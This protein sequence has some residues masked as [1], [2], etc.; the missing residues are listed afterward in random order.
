MDALLQGHPMPTKEPKKLRETVRYRA[1]VAGALLVSLAI[2]IGSGVLG[3]LNARAQ[4]EDAA[5][6]IRTHA[7]LVVLNQVETAM[8]DAETGQRG[9]LL[10]G[11]KEFL[12]PWLA[13][14]GEGTVRVIRRPP[15]DALLQSVRKL[16][17]TNSTENALLGRVD[18][19][20][21]EKLAELKQTIA[22]RQAGRI[23]DALTI[24]R[25]GRGKRIMDAIRMA[26]SDM[27]AE[28]RRQLEQSEARRKLA[29]RRAYISAT[30]SC[31]VSVLA[32][33]LLL[34]AIRRSSMDVVREKDRFQMLADH[35]SQH[36]WT[37]DGNGRFEW[38]NWRWHEFTGAAG[39]DLDAQWRAASDH[40]AHRD[41]VER[42]LLHAVESGE[43]WQDIFPLRA[44]DGRWH[45]FMVC[46][47]PIRDAD[48]RVRRWFGTNTNIDERWQLEQELKAGN[49]R[50]DEFIATLAHEL[51]NPLAPIQAG[52]ELMRINPAFPPPLAKTREV[53]RR[54]L[55]HLVRLIDDLLDVSRISTGK[56]ELMRETVPLR[57]IVESA[58][59]VSRLHIETC[60]HTLDVCLPDEPLVVAADPV[61]LAQVLSNLLNNG[62]KYTPAGGSIRLAAQR[63]GNEVAVCVIDNG[64]GIDPAV[65][66]DIFDLFSQ[67]P[68]GSEL[69]Q[70]GIGIGLSIARKLVELHGG[71]LVAKSAG[72]GHGSCFV[73]RLPLAHAEALPPAT[74]ATGVAAPAGARQRILILDD[75]ED[76]AQTLGDL[77]GLMGHT[78][79]LAHTGREA[80]TVAHRFRPEIAFL[81]IGL[82]DIS[83]YE[84]A[85]LIRAA[86][87]LEGIYLVALTG[88]GAAED[89]AKSAEAGFDLHLTKP[90]S[91]DALK[92]ALPDLMAESGQ[93]AE[94]K[95]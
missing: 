92:E 25:E 69:R 56:L 28:E 53:M 30:A 22:L 54:Q 34:A 90:V 50:R 67:A 33:L 95:G 68:H 13:A 12:E 39:R 3:Y 46:A 84:V 6:V 82:P 38:F 93:G 42:G 29:A 88:W 26:L 47:V 11:E 70:G 83:G 43:S 59:E 61:R 85:R 91:L 27:R 87:E 55:K 32:I 86:P 36:A 9:Y 19:L 49:R 4:D 63:D 7:I 45:W 72:V 57:S 71:S 80:V 66:P 77:L 76:A 2:I 10:T 20:V 23:D 24:V 73:V 16:N 65:L 17:R 74:V 78:V 51:R 79:E 37:L 31:I 52:L 1:S 40:P 94:L 60:G 62:A 21:R 81:D 8:V 64:I 15:I 14:T 5:V 41:R 58:L 75:N 18:A 35:I 89:R 44:H 48:G